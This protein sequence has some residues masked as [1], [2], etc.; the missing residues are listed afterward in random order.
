MAR[1]NDILCL[2]FHCTHNLQ[3][4]D[5]GVI[6]SLKANFNKVCKDFLFAHPG[7]S[8]ESED[9]ISLF[10]LAWPHALTPGNVMKGF[11]QCGI[12]QLMPGVI[13]DRLL[14]PSRAFSPEPQDETPETETFCDPRNI[15]S[16]TNLSD[17]AK[18]TVSSKCAINQY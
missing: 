8:I 7:R 6:K 2:P 5:V 10:S 13:S 11:K 1:E 14:A 17:I 18:S 16:C 4:L 15:S 9:L 3:P 12:F